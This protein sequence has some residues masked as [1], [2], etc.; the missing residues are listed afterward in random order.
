MFFGQLICPHNPD[1]RKVILSN[2]ENLFADLAKSGIHLNSL[3][4]APYDYGGCNCEHC[5]PWI[6]TFAEL[7]RDIFKIAQLYYPDIQLR[8]IGWWWSEEEHSQFAEW[9]DRNAPGLTRSIALHIPYEATCVADVI[10]PKYC[11]RYAFVHIGYAEQAKPR[12]V[13]GKTGPVIASNRLEKTVEKLKSQGVSGVSAYSEGIFDDIN[14]ALLGALFTEKQKTSLETLH[15]Y[16]KRYFGANDAQS[17]EWADW[18]IAW[19]E[20][21]SRDVLDA[22][23]RFNSL[24]GDL[25]NWRQK[26]WE[27]KIDLFNAHQ[28]IMS[29]KD[30]N[31]KRLSNVERFWNAYETLQRDV[32]GTGP[33]RHIFAKKFIGL[34]WYKEW[35][36]YQESSFNSNR[37]E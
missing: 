17:K 11:E 14:K 6:I 20:P 34:P 19:G 26:Q 33:M 28:A 8:F 4:A 7:T 24:P 16:A 22:R 37:D 10:L 25:N 23:N 18:L 9:M 27:I 36:A 12:D 30:W 31:P 21:F 15:V 35:I 13:Y 5:N 3:T 29:E 1:A 32:Y 2:H